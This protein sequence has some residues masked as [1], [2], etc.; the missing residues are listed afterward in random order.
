MFKFIFGFGMSD[1]FLKW[2]VWFVFEMQ[3]LSKISTFLVFTLLRDS[4]HEDVKS[5]EVILYHKKQSN[6]TTVCET[7]QK[8]Y[9]ESFE[10]D[11]KLQII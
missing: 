8:V 2:I 5:S 4:S 6:K 1:L 7:T 11:A 9:L 10:R 3:F